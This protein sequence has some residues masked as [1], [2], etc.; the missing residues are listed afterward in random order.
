MGL[1]Q[2]GILVS[3]TN[4]AKWPVFLLYVSLTKCTVFILLLTHNNFQQLTSFSSLL[5]SFFN[6]HCQS[7]WSF[8]HLWT[9]CGILRSRPPH[10]TGFVTF[11]LYCSIQWCR[12]WT[13]SADIVIS[14]E[15]G[16]SQT[17]CGWQ[18]FLFLIRWYFSLK[19]GSF[20]TSVIKNISSFNFK[21]NAFTEFE[22]LKYQS[23]ILTGAI[24]PI[25][26]QYC[27]SVY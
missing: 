13:R 27:F 7:P 18:I 22:L 15:S 6:H 4:W 21:C 26:S 1:A 16:T 14:L 11:S 12:F 5:S 10:F 19:S 24:S 3:S 25:T 2:L 8:K 23:G 20:V 17:I 9:C